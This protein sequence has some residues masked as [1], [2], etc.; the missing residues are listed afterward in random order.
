VLAYRTWSCSPRMR[1]AVC[2]ALYE[3]YLDLSTDRQPEGC[4]ALA[5]AYLD[6]STVRY[7]GIEFDD[8]LAITEQVDV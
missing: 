8:A 3:S 5:R 1:G 2:T 4:P 6:R 7:L